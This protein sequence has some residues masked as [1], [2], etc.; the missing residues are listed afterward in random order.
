MTK[1]TSS[2]A[3]QWN[4]DLHVILFIVN[5][6]YPPFGILAQWGFQRTD[7][8]CI[9]EWIFL[10][11]RQCKTAT[12]RLEVFALLIARG[13]EI[14]GCDPSQI[15][16][17]LTKVWLDWTQQS[18]SAFQ[19]A[20]VDFVG[21]LNIHFPPHKLFTTL[22]NNGFEDVTFYSSKPVVGFI[23]CTDA[24]RNNHTAGYV[25][26]ANDGWK[27]QERVGHLP[28]PLQTLELSAVV[29]VFQRW[30][31]TPLNIV[32]DSFYVVGIV[33]H[34]ERAVLQGVTDRRL[35]ILFKTLLPLVSSRKRT[36]FTGHIRSHSGLP[37]SLS[38]G[39]DKGDKSGAPAWAGPSVNVF[40]QARTSPAFSPQ[41]VENQC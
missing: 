32:C 19:S 23:V 7:P 29:A 36:Y 39:S 10:P 11:D 4:P 24:S 25:W 20:L 26:K 17:P 8:V 28:A 38:E 15:C 2:Y 6:E 41:S 33:P 21:P 31:D 14:M 18:S 9:L 30:P 12:T 13:Q 37:G 16:L 40:Q 22:K 27:D 5:G 34:L 1:I 3:S 35:R